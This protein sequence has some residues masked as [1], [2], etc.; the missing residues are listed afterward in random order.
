ML[1]FCSSVILVFSVQSDSKSF[2]ERGCIICIGS[3]LPSVP[4]HFT[5]PPSEHLLFAVFHLKCY[6]SCLI[7]LVVP[8]QSPS[9]GSPQVFAKY[10]LFATLIGDVHCM[11]VGRHPED[12]ACGP[13]I[14]IAP[15]GTTNTASGSSP[16]S[17]VAIPFYFL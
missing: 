14:Q 10:I 6:V 1:S 9:D 15:A 17:S 16:L 2:H 11:P 8:V 4:L 7:F 12:L 13:S 5:G 3:K